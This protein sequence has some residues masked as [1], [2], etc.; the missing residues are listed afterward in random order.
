MPRLE[1]DR[2]NVVYDSEGR[3]TR[4]LSGVSFLLEDGKSMG[5]AGESACGKSTLGLAIMR[6]LSGGR[7][8]SGQIRFDNTLILET[9]ESD[10][11][12]KYRWRQISMIFQSAM[13]SLDPVFTIRDQFLEILQ[14]HDTVEDAVARIKAVLESVQ[15][16]PSILGKFPHELSGGMKQ[17]IVIAMALLLRPALVIADEPTTALDVLTQAE[18]MNLL[19]N[20]KKEK[21]AFIIITH[22]MAV[23][24]EIADMIGIMYAGQM[25]EFGSSDDIYDNP[26][27]PYTR[28]LLASIPSIHGKKPSYVRGTPPSLADPPS[29]CRFAARCPHVFE[30]CSIDPPMVKTDTGYVSC[31]LYE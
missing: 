19:K 12:S 21:M 27:H 4:A 30:K 7:V 16:D 13:N 10:F 24:S 5:I 8:M 26:M 28:G 29:G 3:P 25:V 14:Q 22:D 1:V 15:L 18:I 2:L 6:M 17:R 20:L 23:L 31:W 9:N 11:D